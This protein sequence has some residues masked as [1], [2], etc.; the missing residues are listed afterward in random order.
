M[1]KLVLVLVAFFAFQMAQAQVKAGRIFVGGQLSYTSNAQERTNSSS[2]S[3]FYL[4][5]SVGYM[6]SNNF[7]VGAGLGYSTTSID[8]YYNSSNNAVNYT[9]SSIGLAPFVNYYK[10]INGA[11]NFYFYAQ[12]KLGFAS[13]TTK[14]SNSSSSA[15]G[16]DVSFGISPNFVYFPAKLIGIELGFTGLGYTL[17]NPEGDN[18]NSSTFTLGANSFN[19]RI[20]LN[21]WF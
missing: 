9:S 11:E 8:N 2:S 13:T 16:T 15:S 19:P 20:G 7:A 21:F 12:A 14:F 1:K 3:S 10:A 17:S 6:L 18:N 5:P 4:M